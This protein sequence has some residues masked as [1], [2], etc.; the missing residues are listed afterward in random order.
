MIA[1]WPYAALSPLNPIRG[2]I[3]FGDFHYH[4]RTIIFGRMYEMADVPR[5]Y[6][7]T[8]IAIRLPL[9]TLGAAALMSVLIPVRAFASDVDD[10]RRRREMNSVAFTAFFPVLCQVIAQG[11]A[12]DGC[13]HFLFVF[14]PIA[15]LAGIGLSSGIGLLKRWHRNA[16][17]ERPCIYC[18]LL[19]LDGDQARRTPSA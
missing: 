17:I 2:L 19:C 1:A 13:R 5:Y 18:C 4:I 11:P 6:I 9:L 15:V 3:S 8:Y 14:P 10:R 16:M 7:P 12:L